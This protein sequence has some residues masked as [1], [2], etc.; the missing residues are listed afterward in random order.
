MMYREFTDRLSED[1]RFPTDK[2]YDSIDFVYCHHPAISQSG[3]EGQEQIARL[4]SEFG[5]R[6]IAD[7]LPTA[8]KAM[9]LE[10]QRLAARLEIERIERELEELSMV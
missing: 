5:M 1:T 6:I 3:H 8:Q 10:Q 7:M 2:E 9:E 4:Y